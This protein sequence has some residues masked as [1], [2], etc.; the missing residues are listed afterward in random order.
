MAYAIKK[1]S[2]N[3][4]T[5]T[6]SSSVANDATSFPLTSDTNFDPGEGMVIIDEGTASE[7]YAYATGKDGSSLTI[8]LAYRGLEGT[9]AVAHDAGATVKGILT[10]GMWNGFANYM[11]NAWNTETDGAT[12]TFDI[13][14]SRKHLVVLGGNRTLAV[15]NTVSGDTFLIKL[16]QD[17]TG[18]RTVTWFDTISWSGGVAPTLTTTANKSDTFAFICTGSNTYDGF[19]VGQNI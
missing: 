11:R 9:S 2:G 4:A 7:E 5:T 13:D 18:S 12:V 15:S 8:P 3:S 17:A 10:S 14:E 6:L 19:I 1:A 16:K